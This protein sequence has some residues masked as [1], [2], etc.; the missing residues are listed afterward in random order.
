MKVMFR[1]LLAAILG[2][3]AANA[4]SAENF[5]RSGSVYNESESNY[6][7]YECRE[8]NSLEMKCSFIQT[9]VIKPSRADVYNDFTKELSLCEAEFSQGDA[10]KES[11]KMCADLS[12]MLSLAD[13]SLSREEALNL[14]ISGKK[15]SSEN[16]DKYFNYPEEQRKMVAAELLAVKNLCATNSPAEACQGFLKAGKDL[17]ARTCKVHSSKFEQ[18]F[19]RLSSEKTVWTV[20]DSPSGECGV[21]NV[22]RFEKDTDYL[23]RYI[24]QKVVTNPSATAI[25]NMKC[26]ELD[27]GIF[28]FGWKHNGYA[29]NCDFIKFGF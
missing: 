12:V 3:V 1:L 20:Q 21:I 23:W 28:T 26:S 18:R 16:I 11:Q 2:L 25:G 5:P 29:K 24:S 14:E 15:L 4:A 13:G 10:L 6:L 9:S 8:L 22:S 7:T 27:Q 19:S 17:E